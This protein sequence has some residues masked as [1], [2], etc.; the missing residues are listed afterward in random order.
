MFVTMTAS[1]S[2]LNPP[3]RLVSTDPNGSP[4]CALAFILRDP[5]GPG[6][7]DG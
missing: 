5:D 1:L 2:G 6:N 4:L 7:P 3:G